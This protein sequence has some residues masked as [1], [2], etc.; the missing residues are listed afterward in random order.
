MMN[1]APRN[2]RC[3]GCV[4]RLTARPIELKEANDFIAKLHRHHAP[5][6]RD[7]FRFRVVDENGE[8]HGVIQLARPVSRKLDDGD[9]I[10]VVRCCT[11]GTRNA[12]SFLY[13]RAARI[14]KEMGYKKIITYI[15]KSESGVSLKAAG[16]IL[17]NDC[18]GGGSWDVPSRPR[19]LVNPEMNLFFDER[20]KYPTEKKQRWVKNL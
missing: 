13:S 4:E 2:R 15:L 3:A 12:C 1:A 5:V 7:K 16:W 9:T 14:A 18:C 6:H 20:T 10:E 19:N 11:D 8:T 17:E